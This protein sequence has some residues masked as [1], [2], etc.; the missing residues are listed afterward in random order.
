MAVRRTQESTPNPDDMDAADD[1]NAGTALYAPYQTILY[2]APA[3]VNGRVPKNM[4]GNLDVYVP[5]M[6]PAGGAHIPHPETARAAKTVGIDCADAVT[7]FSFKGRHGTAI[8]NGA[9]VAAEFREA[10]EEVI[11]AF[12]DE[13]AQAEDERRSLA[14]LKM[15]KR[16]LAGLRIRERIEGY[17]IEGER[18]MTM[19]YE[20]EQTEDEDE[21]EGGGFL[22]GRDTD[23]LDRPTAKAI[24]ARYLDSLETDDEGGGFCVSQDEEEELEA[25]QASDRFVNMVHDDDDDGDG[26][27]ELHNDERNASEA[28][29]Q[30]IIHENS[31]FVVHASAESDGQEIPGQEGGF[32]PDDGD[33]RYNAPPADDSIKLSNPAD[34]VLEDYGSLDPQGGPPNEKHLDE[35]FPNLPVGELEEARILQQ[36]YESQGHG[37]LPVSKE[38]VNA[39]APGKSPN[40]SPIR[41]TP[42]ESEPETSTHSIKAYPSSEPVVVEDAEPDSSEEDRGSLLSHDPDD[43]DA[44]PEWLA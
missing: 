15:W 7:G 37:H 13:R 25:P 16:F 26:G 24:P 19:R 8:T 34:G 42:G 38:D 39:P 3:V 17:D 1:D 27:F 12:E 41:E 5:S 28:D 2:T 32:L 14:A 33:T 40:S 21:D 43:E 36:V 11:K 20:M 35:A 4:Y 31:K 44:D 23:E 6:V 22:P 29:H 10:V 30:G 18:D 9:V